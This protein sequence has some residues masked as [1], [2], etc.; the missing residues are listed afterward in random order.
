MASHARAPRLA[1]RGMAAALVIGILTVGGLAT[2]HEARTADLQMRRT[3]LT[4]ASMIAAALDP[5]RVGRLRGSAAD[6]EGPDYPHLRAVLVRVKSQNPDY[7]YLYLM[8]KRAGGVPFFFMGTAPDDSPD[9]SPPGQ[10]YYEEA[11]ALESVFATAT[12]RVS[13]P[14]TD[15]WGTWI[16][17][18]VPVV[19]ADTGELQAVFGVDFDA[20]QW[21]SFVRRRAATPAVLSLVAALLVMT[22]AAQL[23][24][25][26]AVR[27]RELAQEAVAALQRFFDVTPDLLAIVGRD[28]RFLRANDAWEEALGRSA[29]ELRSHPAAGLACEADRPALEHLLAE[30]LRAPVTVRCPRPSGEVRFLEWRARR[31]DELVYVAT[32]DVTDSVRAEEALRASRENLVATLNSIADAV[33]ATDETGRVTA[34]NPVCAELTGWAEE[35]AVGR[36]LSTVVPL[37]DLDTGAALVDPIAEA[38]AAGE[39]APADG[40]AAMTGRDGAERTVAFRAAPLRGP[41]DRVSGGVLAFRDV[42]EQRRMEEQLR[43]QQRLEAVGTLAGGIAHDFNNLLQV[44]LGHATLG[45]EAPTAAS[46]A[47]EYLVPI[48]DAGERAA[49]LVSQ[50]LAFSRRQT[51]RP[52]DIDLNTV[53]GDLLKMLARLIGAN[54]R[55]EF[56]PGHVLSTVRADRGLLEQVLMNLCLNARDAM[57]GGGALIIETENVM[58]DHDYCALYPWARPGRYV[59]LTVTDT[60]CGMDRAT[61]ERVYEPFFTTKEAGRGTGLGLAMVYGIVKQHD[62]MIQAY[63]EPN[64]GTAFKVY[65]PAVE[66]LATAVGTRIEPPAVGGT[67]TILL[68]EDDRMVLELTR[69]VLE[70]AGYT[71]IEAHDGEQAVLRYRQRR[72]E[73][74]ALVLDVVMPGL[75]G[76]EVWERLRASFGEVPVIFTSGYTEG[77][78]HTNFVLDEG[79]VLLEKPFARNDLLRALRRVLDQRGE[80]AEA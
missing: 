76:R 53:V 46:A 56:T 27:E 60:G 20:A 73:I 52:A 6:L 17:A 29:E 49:A 16:S 10:E 71:V 72:S 64:V 14:T 13:A 15:R 44:I 9:Y 22:L 78:L 75:G 1:G 8:G 48:R 77:A 79:V 36:S 19:A 43:H 32:R 18:L 26:H 21:R 51:L 4:E 65:L 57:P 41:G 66:R 50:L 70:L 63:S 37:R 24:R 74:D 54:I 39:A 11:P 69:T 35:S 58:V 3:M 45:L 67:E 61:L 33:V 80:A 7:R 38:I 34:L 30:G 68:A 25:R 40:L 59:L 28:G 2:W 31:H 12:A 55:L 42:T 23:Q 5:E 47:G 62:G